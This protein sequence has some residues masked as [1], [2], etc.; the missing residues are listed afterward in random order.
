MRLLEA[1]TNLFQW[2][3]TITRARKFA[4]EV[5]KFETQKKNTIQLHDSIEMASPWD[6]IIYI[7]SHI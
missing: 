1:K 5:L 7:T 3:S 4:F 6:S 2:S